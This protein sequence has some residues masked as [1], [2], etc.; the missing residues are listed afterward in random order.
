MRRPRSRS[1]W[2]TSIGQRG[3]DAPGR[4]WP[5]R[6]RDVRPCGPGVRRYWCGRAPALATGVYDAEASWRSDL[7]LR[8]GAAARDTNMG[9]LDRAMSEADGVSAT[10][11]SAPRDDDAVDGPPG[12]TGRP[13]PS[14]RVLRVI[15]RLN[16][17]GPATHVTLAD[18]GLA[19]LGWETL[20]VHGVV[21]SNEA[22]I[23][24]AAM[25]IPTRRLQTLHRAID[26]AEDVRSLVALAR[27]IRAYRP[28]VIH[29]HLS[30]AGLVGR[31]A[32]LAHLACGPDPHVPWQ[33]LR[34]LLRPSDV[35]GDPDARTRPRSLHPPHRRPQR[36]PAGGA[37][38]ARDRTTR[39]DPDRATRPGSR[40]IRR[41]DRAAAR[42][43]WASRTTRWSCSRSAASS[44]SS[45]S[46]PHRRGRD[47]RAA[48]PR[49]A[50]RHRRR[51]RGADGA[52][53]ESP[54]RAG[55]AT[56]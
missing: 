52:R 20:L 53:G 17:G 40:P 49:P 10:E 1:R 30:K 54:R 44:R 39:P 22:E 25:D 55:S 36:P 50:A 37:A 13:A 47:R 34:R 5:V 18:R 38:R 14:Q 43:G 24:I 19:T 12:R 48:H 32:A 42:R 2:A 23:D 26:P 56:S 21:E 27:V 51:R 7:S 31:A 4:R 11:P 41:P 28:H 16:V 46:T 9:R 45:G 8:S 6:S 33:R 3:V 35:P 15:T 29:T